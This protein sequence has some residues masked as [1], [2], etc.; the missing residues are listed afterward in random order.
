M[1]QSIQNRPT[2]SIPEPF[3]LSIGTLS[4]PTSISNDVQFNDLP[5]TIDAAPMPTQN[6]IIGGT[7]GEYGY[8]T[9]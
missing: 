8:S 3:G 4:N 5:G 2:P 6:G 9:L 1:R 7:F